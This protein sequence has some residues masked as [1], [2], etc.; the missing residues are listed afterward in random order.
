MV[1][2]I[3]NL[4]FIINTFSQSKASGERLLEVLNEKDRVDD[5]RNNEARTTRLIGEV[6]FNQVSLSYGNMKKKALENVSFKAEKGKTIGLVG[7]TGSGKSSI[8]Q[9][10]TRFYERSDGEILI[11][12][13]PIESYALKDLRQNIGVVL[14][15]TFFYFLQRFATILPM[16]GRIFQWIKS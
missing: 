3:M 10:I 9:L 15:E 13:Q 5:A 6:T 7:A 8:I 14:Q 16:A 1:G 11:D 4:G 2:P 12:G